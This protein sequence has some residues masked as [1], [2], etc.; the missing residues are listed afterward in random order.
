MVTITAMREYFMAEISR[1]RN[2]VG[3]LRR[4][5][6]ALRARRYAHCSRTAQGLCLLLWL[7]RNIQHATGFIAIRESGSSLWDKWIG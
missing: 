4:A 1:S 7:V 5:V 2:V 3:T 6:R